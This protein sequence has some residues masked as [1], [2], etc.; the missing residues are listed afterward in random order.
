MK[1]FDVSDVKQ[2]NRS[3]VYDYIRQ[4]ELC[5]RTEIAKANGISG[6]TIL[7]ISGFLLDEGL[8]VEAGEHSETVGRKPQLLKSN[9]NRYFA[10]GALVEGAYV[11]AGLVNL[12]AELHSVL[13]EKTN[14]DLR[15][16]MMDQLP[17]M[18]TRLITDSGLSKDRILGAGIGLPCT[19]D[20]ENHIISNGPLVLVQGKMALT[21]MEEELSR[22]CGLPIIVDNDANMQVYGEYHARK[23]QDTDLIYISIGTGLGAGIVLDGKLRRGSNYQ[24]GEIGYMVFD[25]KHVA[26]PQQAGWLEQ[27]ISIQTLNQKFEK[28]EQSNTAFMQFIAEKIA[29]AITNIVAVIDCN[30]I[31]LGGVLADMLGEPLVEEVRATIRRLSTLEISVEGHSCPDPGIVGSATMIIQQKLQVLF[32][33]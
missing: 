17:R 5:S 14:N 11:H 12:N 4:H 10:I 26:D 1:A 2:R 19:Y 6:P 16:I 31:C 29:V 33:K 13:K 27:I 30:T 15:S 9:P 25:E 22:K 32:E 21:K 28:L 3:K 24:C 23:L 8:V 18:I 7:K 20:T